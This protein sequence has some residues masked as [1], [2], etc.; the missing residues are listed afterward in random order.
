MYQNENE[1]FG[2]FV[3]DLRREKNMTQKELA[4]QLFV[5]DKAVSKWERG[6]SMPNVTLLLPLAEILGVTVTELLKG[7][8]LAADRQM[9]IH[10]VE[11]LVTYSVGMSAEQQKAWENKK[12]V[13][14]QRYWCCFGAV[15]GE[16][17]VLIGIG[18]PLVEM[19]ASVFLVCGLMMLF[20]A[21]ACFGMEPRLPAYY[22]EN[23]ISFVQQG[24][25]KI[26]MVG[27]CFNNRN[28]PHIVDALRAELLGVS[29]GYPPVFYLIYR[30]LGPW[31][32]EGASAVAI[33]VQ[34]T[35]ALGACLLLF[36]PIVWM[37][38]K[39]K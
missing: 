26:S 6:L 28:W 12:G 27:I 5:S 13:W 20:G 21:W 34:M 23:P 8:R 25:F 18:V 1:R 10:E 4:D 35:A 31:M 19:T 33:A 7:E 32:S 37:A 38:K 16:I 29:V 2:S 24:P 30:F 39:Y 36:L 17:A 11:E 9:G 15:L 22:D 3:A 14:K